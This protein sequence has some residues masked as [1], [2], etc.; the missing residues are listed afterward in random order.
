VVVPAAQVCCGALHAHNGRRDEARA[1]ARQNIDALLP[2]GFDA[3]ISNTGG[4]GAT[5]K[6]Y[7]ELLEHDDR[8]HDLARQFVSRLKDVNEFLAGIDLNP[9]MGPVRRRVTYQDSCHLC[10]GQ[11]VKAAPR[12]LLRSIPGLDFVEMPA[13]DVCCGSA[14]IYNV[15][16]AEMAAEILASKMRNANAVRPEQIASSNP[17]CMIQLEAGCRSLG[18]GKL[19]DSAQPVRH[20][21]ELLDEAYANYRG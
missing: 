21:V 20:V 5:L 15:V 9:N 16:Q 14:G 11:K 19:K 17:G 4:C 12:K 3:I 13:S 18:E 6:E 2:G 7:H 1:Q 10:H 8:Y